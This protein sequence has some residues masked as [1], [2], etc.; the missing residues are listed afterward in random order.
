MGPP[1]YMQFVVGRNVVTR[2]MPV[3]AVLFLPFTGGIFSLRICRNSRLLV[4]RSQTLSLM[5]W[6]FGSQQCHVLC[7][8]FLDISLGDHTHTY[9]YIT[10]S[11]NFLHVL[12]TCAGQM[13]TS[14]ISLGRTRRARVAL[15]HSTSK[16]ASSELLFLPV[17]HW[18]HCVP[19]FASSSLSVVTRL[20]AGKPMGRVSNPDKGEAHRASCLVGTR[21]Y[22]CAGKLDGAWS[23]HSPPSNPKVKNE[24]RYSFILPCAVLACIEK[25]YIYPYHEIGWYNPYSG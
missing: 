2:R 19:I 3:Y 20:R 15:R 1:S 25:L 7:C 13:R 10:Q 16:R 6:P 4:Q 12:E 22:F 21:C 18:I 14:F 9:T 17:C 11:Q 5:C 8:G 23:W 24:S